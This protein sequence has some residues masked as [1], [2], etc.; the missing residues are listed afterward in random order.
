MILLLL[1]LLL[2]PLSAACC[3]G[4][5]AAAR[6]TGSPTCRACTTCSSCAHCR[7]GGTCG[8]CEPV[9]IEDLRVPEG[10]VAVPVVRVVDGDTILVRQDR[11]E[12]R[13]RLV[14][15]DTPE[16]VHPTKPVERFGLEASARMRELVGGRK[17][18]LVFDPEG[19]RMDRYGRT[20]AHVFRDDGL[21]VNRAMVADGYAFAYTRFPFRYMGMF[22]EA[23]Q[24]AR[25]A[26]RGL[27]GP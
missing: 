16:T 21:W 27:W 22:R 26:G 4:A 25:E 10:A 9:E 14:G 24:E 19:D 2:P 11:R 17:V 23:E 12:V 13:V 5:L 6:C 20:I 1:C 15:I 7:A 18:Y 3:D 8:V